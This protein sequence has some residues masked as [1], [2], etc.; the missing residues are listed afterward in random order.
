MNSNLKCPVCKGVVDIEI[1]YENGREVNSRAT[2]QDCGAT[3]DQDDGIWYEKINDDK[4]DVFT[5][6]FFRSGGRIP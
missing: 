2:C 5:G 1:L 3:S 4:Y 6:P